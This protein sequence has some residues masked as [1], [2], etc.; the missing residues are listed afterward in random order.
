M[1]KK[2]VERKIIYK[3]VKKIDLF[4]ELVFLNQNS[5]YTIYYCY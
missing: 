4:L 1:V 3:K 2:R 5:E